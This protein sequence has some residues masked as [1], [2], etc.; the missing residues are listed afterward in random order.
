MLTLTVTLACKPNP[1]LTPTLTVTRYDS[2]VDMWALGVVCYMLLSGTRPFHHQDRHEK[3]RR[4]C[5]DPLQ[6]PSPGPWDHVSDAAKDFCNKLMQK[7]PKDRMP[8]SE[9]VHHPW[10]KQQSTLHSGEDAAHEMQRHQD[11][12]D[13]LQAFS[14]ADDL[15]RV[16]L[17]VIAFSTPPGKLEELRHM[18]VNMD[19]DDSGTLSIRALPFTLPLNPNPK[20][21]VLTLT[22]T[23]KHDHKPHP[24]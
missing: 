2:S 18:F 1:T 3:K 21:N 20:A 4:I 10:I 15:K 24:G 6:F 17:E 19:T 9:A 5:H 16:A 14:E 11:I 22:L 23:L 8:A 12:V 7:N 13:S